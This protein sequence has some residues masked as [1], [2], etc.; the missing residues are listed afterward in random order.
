MS[1]FFSGTDQA[2]IK[3]HGK[4]GYFVGLV[5]N[6]KGDVQI[7]MA[8]S[9]PKFYINS[10]LSLHITDKINQEIKERLDKEYIEKVSTNINHIGWQGGN[11]EAQY[12]KKR[13][14]AYRNDYHGY[15]EDDFGYYGANGKWYDNKNQEKIDQGKQRGE[16]QQN[17]QSLLN[18]SQTSKQKT[19]KQQEKNFQNF[20]KQKKICSLKNTSNTLGLIHAITQ[21]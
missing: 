18:S 14:Y 8:G 2:T 13:N 21:S 10:G 20:L 7:G 3:D 11:W 1:A 16:L 12:E 15:N 19:K 17:K 9:K 4:N 5:I 6:K